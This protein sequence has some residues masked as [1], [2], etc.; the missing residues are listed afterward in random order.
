[1]N[2]EG[3]SFISWPENAQE[4]SQTRLAASHT[5]YLACWLYQYNLYL[6]GRF[7]KTAI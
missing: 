6:R 5:G 4:S 7:Q 3:H 1:M 2:I